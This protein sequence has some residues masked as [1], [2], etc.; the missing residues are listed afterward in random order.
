MANKKKIIDTTWSPGLAYVVGLLATDGNLSPD[1]RHISFTSK[2]EVLALTV[3]RIL[4]LDNK[5]S[6]KARGGEVSKKY[7]VTQFGSVDFYRFLLSIGL[8]PAKSKTLQRLAIPKI[9]FQHFLR[10]C[11]DGDGNICEF[12]H[13]QSRQTQLRVRLASASPVFLKWIHEE[14][15]LHVGVNGGWIYRDQKKS[16][17]TL[18][19]AKNDAVKILNYIYA[20][21]NDDFLPRKQKTATNY[22]VVKDAGMAKL[23]RRA[24]LRN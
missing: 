16:V 1:A 2:D 9:Y 14:V 7:Y 12:M 18:T 3:K 22:L 23:V 6:M 13:P 21:L 15:K 24:S 11:I 19:F 8:T 17:M 10:G 5:I 20:D 4:K